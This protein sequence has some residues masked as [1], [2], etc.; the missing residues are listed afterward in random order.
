VANPAGNQSAVGQCGLTGRSSRPAPAGV[1]SLGR[2]TFGIFA[3][4]AYATCLHGSAQLYVRPHKSRPAMPCAC[5]N[6]VNSVCFW[7]PRTERPWKRP[8]LFLLALCFAVG[9]CALLWMLRDR[10][11]YGMFVLIAA[12]LTIAAVLSMYVA[13]AGC[14]A[15]VARLL[16]EA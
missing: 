12:P 4:Q 10:P 15:C 2:G 6:T 9:G 16:G 8:L 5:C 3:A 1:V 14:N 13:L 7:G 11:N